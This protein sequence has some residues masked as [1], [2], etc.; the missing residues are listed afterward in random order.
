MFQMLLWK[1]WKENLW[2]LVFCGAASVV[3]T[4][5]LFRIRIIPDFANCILIS[6]VQM[7]A[8]PVI[9]SL[10]IFSGEISNR[11]VHLL[12]K[13]PVPRWMLFFSKYLV[14]AVG[15]ILIFLISGLLMEFISQGREARIL[16]LLKTNLLYSMAA[17]VLF[18]WFCAFGCQS[19]S[20]AGSLVAMFGVFIGW[21]IVLFWS[22]LCE[23][24]WAERFVPYSLMLMEFTKVGF[25]GIVFSQIPTS[26]AILGIACYRYTSIRRYL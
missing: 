9:Y 18:T 19:R 22:N 23:V 25:V 7:F 17:L 20:E 26:L 21:G 4:I 2:K 10:D 8:V 12:F 16:F 1:E 13:I 5:M 24:A 15:I 14:S 6:F 11:T 3:F